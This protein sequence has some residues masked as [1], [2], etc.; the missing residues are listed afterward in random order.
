MRTGFCSSRY[1][2]VP[3]LYRYSNDHPEISS[4]TV[5]VSPV[6]EIISYMLAMQDLACRCHGPCPPL[7]AS[8]LL[9]QTPIEGQSNV[10]VITCLLAYMLLYCV[11]PDPER[12]TSISE[13]L[14]RP[15]LLHEILCPMRRVSACRCLPLNGTG[16]RRHRIFDGTTLLHRADCT[17]SAGPQRRPANQK[18]LHIE[19]SQILLELE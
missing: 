2:L 17:D 4:S 14:L 7:I 3:M 5:R 13:V 12:R 6:M 18:H 16:N 19:K 1:S 15:W 8:S 11:E 10:S 9:L